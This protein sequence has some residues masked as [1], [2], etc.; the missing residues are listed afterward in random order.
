MSSRALSF[1]HP[2]LSLLMLV[3][4]VV[5]GAV[6]TLAHAE[7][8]ITLAWNAGDEAAGYIVY[9][10]EENSTEPIKL[11]V[12][13]STQTVVSGLKEGLNYTFY[14]TAYN[15]VRIESPPSLP[16]EFKVP[17]PMQMTPP[18]GN[19][20][21]R[22]RFPAAPGRWY[23]LQASTDLV[24]WTTIWQTGKANNYAWMEYQD[25]RA[26]YYTSRFYRLQVH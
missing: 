9:A 24:N 14:V 2:I 6:P 8:S 12:G 1:F 26:R 19:V 3:I 10:M 4:G 18:N 5:I 22:I 15:P 13:E 11:D 20:P 21:G 23:E 17:V 16:I 7:R 25:P